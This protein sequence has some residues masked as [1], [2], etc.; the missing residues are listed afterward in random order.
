MSTLNIK[1]RAIMDRW[2]AGATV[3]RI[4]SDLNM[5][6]D[7][8]FSIIGAYRITDGEMRRRRRDMQEG[9][10][11]LLAAILSVRGAAAC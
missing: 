11:K 1:E 3:E 5:P 7:R 4:S 2:D 10:A 9:S 6:E 8:V